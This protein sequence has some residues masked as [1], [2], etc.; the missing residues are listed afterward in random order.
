MVSG[1]GM[2]RLTARAVHALDRIF[3]RVRVG[4]R[5]SREAYS[6]WE[7]REGKELV[8]RYA[9]HFG[10]LEGMSVLDVG[11][12]MGGKTVA[13]ADEGAKAIG[14]DISREHV[15]AAV[16]FAGSRGGRALFLV[17]DAS[18]LPFRDESFGFVVANDSMEHFSEPASALAD[19]SRILAPGGKL[20]LFFTPWR[21]PLGSHLYDYIKMPWCHLLL[22]ERVIEEVL[23][24]VLEERGEQDPA[25]GARA[26]MDEY[27]SELNRITIGRYRRI[28]RNRP[29]LE[30]LYERLLPPKFE[31]LGFLTRLPAVGEFFTGTVIALLR[32]S[33]GD[34]VPE[35]H[36]S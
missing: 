23:R 5:G 33:G 8:S 10:P 20:L 12:G 17:G 35:R 27:R 25:S 11:C 32:K 21:S 1:S 13:Y 14:L 2:A 24:I 28:V 16:R 4:G 22:N 7:Y 3:P 29:E 30:T 9:E 34:E 19:L 18:S 6:E 15:A 26:L 31:A 36:S